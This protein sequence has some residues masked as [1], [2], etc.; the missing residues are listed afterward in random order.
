MN[1]NGYE[2]KASALRALRAKG[3]KFVGL[4]TAPES[5]PK[6]YK[7]MKSGVMTSPLHLAPAS[8]SGWNVCPQAS[9]GCIA[10]CLHTAGNPAYMAQK[11]N[12]RNDKT[13]AYIEN[14]AAFMA[15]LV[16]EI[17]ALERKAAKMDMACGVRLNA[18]SDIAWERVPVTVDG[19]KFTNV[20]TAF[21]EITFYDYTKVTKRAMAFANKS[22]RWPSNYHITF[23]KSETNYSDVTKVLKAGGNVA[24]VFEKAL[25]D[26]WQG[27]PV[28]NGDE[29]D[30]RPHDGIGVIAGLKAKGDAKSDESG[31]VIRGAV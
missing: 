4:L 25:P 11:F 13:R 24:A 18:T 7:N 26:T 20:M 23:S 31:F 29:T 16:L 8:V 1:V 21:P 28:I 2:T 12:S 3:H 22:P 19:V 27:V 15:L 30:F 6:V 14:R 5:N 10:A 9:E 17:A